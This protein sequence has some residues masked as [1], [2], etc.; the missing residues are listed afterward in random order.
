MTDASLP[1]ST[2]CPS[3]RRK[4]V[5]IAAVVASSMA[6]IDGTVVSIAIPSIRADLE[7]TLVGVQWINNAY[8]LVLSAFILAG[9]AAGDR[10]GTVRIFQLGIVLFTLASL[11]CAIAID[12]ATLIVAR[13]LQ[14]FGAAIMIPG[15]LAIISKSY[16]K[17]ERG[18]A[19]GTW[20]AASAVTTAMGP[21]IGGIVLTLGDDNIWRAIFAIN[22]PMG[23]LAIWLLI[24]K[25]PRDTPHSTQSPDILGAVLVTLALGLLAWALTGEGGEG[26]LPDT[27]RMIAYG[28]PALGVFA[29][30]LFAQ[31]RS[32]HPMMPLRL[33]AM[34]GFSAA[35]LLTFCIYCAF[36]GVLFFL[37]MTLV[38]GWGLT[39][40][41]TIWSFAPL[42]VAI[43]LLSARMGR[44]ADRIGVRPVLT[45]GT[46]TLTTAFVGLAL[47][48]PWQAYWA[49][50]VPM[51]CL[52]ALGMGMIVAPLSAAVMQ[53]VEEDD[54]GIAS[55]VNNAVSRAS[56]LIAI[57]AMGGLATFGAGAAG[58]MSFGDP[59]MG[60]TAMT[61]GFVAVTWGA[62]ALGAFATLVAWFGLKPVEN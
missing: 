51:M 61:A 31:S 19:I 62:A 57:A 48:L 47:G 59:E 1:A 21:I 10:F 5:L 16:P 4:F 25:V 20:A 53:S 54:S 8:A 24:S 29:A 52:M 50:V 9:G 42:S 37:P 7:T 3:E 2:F 41:E 13:A 43:G 60:A 44:L 36:A 46:A 27:G 23:A 17:A 55:G 28:L 33:F 6:F 58:G 26:G 11:L 35:N 34:P 56:N 15:S 22:L 45:L 12:A 14:G 30:F 38:T 32:A 49:H 40:L 18:A 39:E